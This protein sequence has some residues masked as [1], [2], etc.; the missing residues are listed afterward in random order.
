MLW[1][2]A[3]TTVDDALMA[4]IVSFVDSFAAD[5]EPR[6]RGHITEQEIEALLGRACALIAM[7]VMPEPRSS[8]PIPWPA[9]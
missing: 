2:W 4:D 7:P 9:F 8:R 5:V 1:G 6:L 3:G